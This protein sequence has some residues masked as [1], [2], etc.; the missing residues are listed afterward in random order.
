MLGKTSF[1]QLNIA[2]FEEVKSLFADMNYYVDENG[3]HYTTIE[4]I[5]EVVYDDL[6]TFET[7]VNKPV[8]VEQLFQHKRLVYIHPSAKVLRIT[9]PVEG[10]IDFAFPEP[11]KPGS[12]YHLHINASSAII[13]VGASKN[14]SNFLNKDEVI[15]RKNSFDDSY[16]VAVFDKEGNQYSTGLFISLSGNAYIRIARGKNSYEQYALTE[17]DKEGFSYMTT[18]E[19]EIEPLYVK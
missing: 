6:L 16:N 2:A 12:S 11:I 4:V 9:H 17:S 10:M 15:I 19:S 3:E 8:I 14:K 1:A 5:D 7:N 13:I 18:G